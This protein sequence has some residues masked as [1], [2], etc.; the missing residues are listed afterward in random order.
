[1]RSIFPSESLTS[2][3]S[4]PMVEPVKVAPRL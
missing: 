4:G 2:V 3:P 1:L